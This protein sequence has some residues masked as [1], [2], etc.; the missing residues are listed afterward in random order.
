MKKLCFIFIVIL[1]PVLVVGQETEAEFQYGIKFGMTRYSVMSLEE[2]TL[3]D[4]G[5]RDLKDQGRLKAPLTYEGIDENEDVWEIKY[6]FSEYLKLNEIVERT[7]NPSLYLVFLH[8]MKNELG[9]P[10]KEWTNQ[11]GVEK[12]AHFHV[13]FHDTDRGVKITL[14]LSVYP[15]DSSFYMH[16]NPLQ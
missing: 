14:Q 5:K 1:S 16:F 6:Y 9:E 15:N 4:R 8:D 12:A 11:N 13:V 2:R 3:I 7:N 10:I